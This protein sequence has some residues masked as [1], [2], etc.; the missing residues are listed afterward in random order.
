ML[1]EGGLPRYATGM[2]RRR[3]GDRLRYAGGGIGRS[4]PDPHGGRG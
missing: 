2:E 3:S 4:R 1:K